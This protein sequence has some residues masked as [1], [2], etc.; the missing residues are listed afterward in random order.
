MHAETF[1]VAL[2]AGVASAGEDLGARRRAV[3]RLARLRTE[4]KRYAMALLRTARHGGGLLRLGCALACVFSRLS[5]TVFPALLR[6]VFATFDQAR[7]RA[8]GLHDPVGGSRE[9]CLRRGACRASGHLHVV[10][11]AVSAPSLARRRW[12]LG[13]RGRAARTAAR[14]GHQDDEH[15]NGCGAHIRSMHLP[16][17][18]SHFTHARTVQVRRF[19]RRCGRAPTAMMRPHRRATWN[20]RH[21]SRCR[22]GAIDPSTRARTPR[23]SADPRQQPTPME[24]SGVTRDSHWL[25]LVPMPRRPPMPR[26]IERIRTGSVCLRQACTALLSNDA[27][28]ARPARPLEDHDQSGPLRR[29]PRRGSRTRRTSRP[30]LTACMQATSRPPT[31]TLPSWCAARTANIRSSGRRS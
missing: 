3:R 2:D 14:C 17:L 11:G 12:R 30:R 31:S 16:K 10:G 23:S 27:A 18:W 20:A 9:P 22:P 25:S 6:F 15:V 29:G 1:R 24:R 19:E 13:G 8:P 28:C 4:A 5:A 7:H 21:P 26:W